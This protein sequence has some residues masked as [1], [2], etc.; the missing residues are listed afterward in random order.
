MGR[1]VVF[2]R[3]QGWLGMI[4]NRR[5]SAGCSRTL[6]VIAIAPS[7]ARAVITFEKLVAV[8]AQKSHPVTPP[9]TFRHKADS[10]PLASLAELFVV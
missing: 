3:Q 4:Q 9:H 10:D 5:Y 1:E 2:E 6:K 8:G 7:M